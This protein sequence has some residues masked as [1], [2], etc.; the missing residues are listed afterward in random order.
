MLCHIIHPHFLPKQNLLCKNYFRS[1]NYT[2]CV[3]MHLLLV[4]LCKV[5]NRHS[6]NWHFP[7]QE[8]YAHT[9]TVFRGDPD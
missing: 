6:L 9:E 8:L 5:H 7:R 4:V 1:C 3:A 2:N